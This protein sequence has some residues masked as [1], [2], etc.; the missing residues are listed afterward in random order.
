MD[1]SDN[2]N[3]YYLYK[4]ARV[5][6]EGYGTAY[7]YYS[8]INFLINLLKKREISRVLIYG[9]PE[10]YG[11][12]MDKLIIFGKIL[13]VREIDIVE[14]RRERLDK[15]IRISKI[16]KLDN[17]VNNIFIKELHRF[18]PTKTYDLIVS[19]DVFHRLSHN[20]KK[21]YSETVI[22]K[23]KYY[24]IFVP[25]K[26]IGE[27]ELKTLFNDYNLFDYI[28]CPPFPSGKKIKRNEQKGNIKI[29]LKDKLFLRVLLVWYYF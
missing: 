10:K 25:N 28:D 7:E 5:E 18:T 4:V 12:S 9:L 20:E 6:G 17:Y 1:T 14:P 29:S 21:K 24:I 19:T 16:L 11:F 2:I 26:K 22:K 8:K 3:I 27:N 13:K 23:S 15:F